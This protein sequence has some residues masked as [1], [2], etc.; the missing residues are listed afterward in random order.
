MR[1]LSARVDQQTR[2]EHGDPQPMQARRRAH[3]ILSRQIVAAKAQCLHGRMTFGPT[4]DIAGIGRVASIR[5][6]RLS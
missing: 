4:D 3:N 2:R 6:P 5:S 1:R